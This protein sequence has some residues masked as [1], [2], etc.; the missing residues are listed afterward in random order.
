M[1]AQSLAIRSYPAEY[2]VWQAMVC[3]CTQPTH[4]AYE[5][6]GGRGIVVCERWHKQRLDGGFARFVEDMGAMP[7]PGYT[8][9]RVDNDKGYEPGNCRWATRKE[10]SRNTSTNR[11]L[12]FHGRTQCLRAWAEESGI[13]ENAL[14]GRLLKGWPHER[15]L[16]PLRGRRQA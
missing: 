7:A 12:T 9:D 1:A 2:R 16:A 3:R 5:R 11:L 8:I 10:Q 14:R 15:L 4:G 6:Y 13:T